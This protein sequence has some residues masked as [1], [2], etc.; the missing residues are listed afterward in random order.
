M[1]YELLQRR[2]YNAAADFIDSNV[3]RGLAGKVAFRDGERALTYGELQSASFRFAAALRGLGLR[4]EERLALIL[5][6]TVNFPVAF[7]GAVRAGIVAIPLNTLLTPEQY[8][9]ILA[10]SRAAALFVSAPP[11]EPVP[12]NS[13]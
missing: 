11:L 8:G 10:D 5:P 7:W 9:Y 6:D 4:A 1:L 13:I 3:A 2:P 12:K